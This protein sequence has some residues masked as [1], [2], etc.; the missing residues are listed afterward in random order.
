[1][2]PSVYITTHQVLTSQLLSLLLAHNVISHKNFRSRSPYFWRHDNPPRPGF[3]IPEDIMDILLCAIV[4]TWIQNGLTDM[5]QLNLDGEELRD[6]IVKLVDKLLVQWI[7]DETIGEEEKEE[8]VKELMQ[9]CPEAEPQREPHPKVPIH[10]GKPH[11]SKL[12]VPRTGFHWWNV[13]GKD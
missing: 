7:F 4:D 3:E 2:I 9:V 13:P 8:K 11:Q 5:G 12:P 1:M 6:E 10:T